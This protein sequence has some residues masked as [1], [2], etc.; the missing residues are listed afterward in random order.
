MY[1]GYPASAA[2][3]GDLATEFSS[4]GEGANMTYTLTFSEAVAIT[5]VVMVQRMMLDGESVMATGE[6]SFGSGTTYPVNFINEIDED[7]SNAYRALTGNAWGVQ[8]PTVVPMAFHGAPDTRI[9]TSVTFSAKTMELSMGAFPNSGFNEF[10]V[11]T[12]PF[13][14]SRLLCPVTLAPMS[15]YYSQ[16]MVEHYDICTTAKF[17][18]ER[19]KDY[20]STFTCS[21]DGQKILAAMSKLLGFEK[22]LVRGHTTCAA[23]SPDVMAGYAIESFEG[24]M[25]AR[26]S[27]AYTDTQTTYIMANLA[28]VWGFHIDTI[29]G[30]CRTQ[31]GANAVQYSVPF[32]KDVFDTNT[33]TRYTP[34]QIAE[35]RV[36][37]DARS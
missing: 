24:L 14:S 34:N 20:N 2:V 1:E 23:L 36:F 37:W 31:E 26:A 5:D 10:T 9:A 22:A 19:M 3:D 30:E 28:Y 4:D 12:T 15:L 8:K 6:V 7:K 18:S 27:G 21:A 16:S 25:A 35:I 33:K 11:V 29:N 13:D 17:T 32:P